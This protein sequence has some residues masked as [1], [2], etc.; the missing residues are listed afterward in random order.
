MPRR[1]PA[2]RK[3]RAKSQVRRGPNRTD[4]LPSTSGS[5]TSPRAEPTVA[6]ST[7]QPTQH[8]P[9]R[10]ERKCRQLQTPGNMPPP[11]AVP[12]D[13]SKRKRD[14]SN[15]VTAQETT[16]SENISEVDPSVLKRTCTEPHATKKLR[17]TN[18][19]PNGQA[20]FNLK[21]TM[22]DLLGK[23][24][25]GCVFEG[26]R[27]S[28]GLQVAIKIIPK[29]N[30]GC[31]ITVPD[32][33]EYL[34]LEVALMTIVSRP[35]E[36]PNILKLVEWFALPTV[37]I[38]ILERP[39]PCMDLYNYC[40]TLGGQLTESQGKHIIRQVVHAVKHCRDRSVLHRD[41]KQD[42]F[43]VNT[44]DVMVKLIDFGCG[45]LLKEGRYDSFAGT[46]EF[47][48]PEWWL[49]KTYQ[50]RPATIW[51]LG[52]LLYV[53]LCGELPFVDDGEIVSKRLRCRRGLSSECRNL[54]H[55]CLRKDPSKRPVLEEILQHK[56]LSAD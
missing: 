40:E 48:P 31:Y 37:F 24:G 26:T 56:W 33:G 50:G 51:S 42:N 9:M 36:C 12:T 13:K 29:E 39:M 11:A 1:L 23:G 18:K 44:D 2:E 46:E 28:D 34:P 52:V 43:L 55:W 3:S 17:K 22:G 32:T 5:S 14:Y 45:D 54:I 15:V 27:H 19:P 30:A 47:S 20:S 38:L 10:P 21:Y 6:P 41:I 35:P 7:S 53:L 49:H 4:V 25:C 8:G 16:T